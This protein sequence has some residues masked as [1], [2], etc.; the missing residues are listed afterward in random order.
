MRWPMTSND[1]EHL[2]ILKVFNNSVV[3]A[4][5]EQGRET[6]LLGRG[7]GFQKSGGDLVENQRVERRFLPGENTTGEQVHAYLS[8][9]DTDDV[10]MA[11]RIISRAR[12]ELGVTLSDGAILPLADHISTAIMRAKKNIAM[13]YPLKWELA[14]LYPREV[15]FAEKTVGVIERV[16]SVEL[17]KSE[18]MPL[19]MH[20]VNAQLGAL[21]VSTAMN[22]TDALN[23]SL[24]LVRERVGSRRAMNPTVAARFVSHLRN[25]ITRCMNG[26][27]VAS[28]APAVA[29]ALEQSNTYEL[30]LANEV[31]DCLE[32]RFKWPISKDERLYLTIHIARLVR[33]S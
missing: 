24:E 26:I 15:A 14:S 18:A 33:E 9:L 31:A 2:W 21:E 3:L 22:V 25:L 10:V 7:V 23:D 11:Q 30:G 1:A 27:P 16:R 32:T 8:E 28:M 17:P 19:V 4:R 6:V 20:L 12:E 13:D 29:N 5:D